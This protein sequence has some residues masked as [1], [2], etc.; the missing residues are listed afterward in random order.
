MMQ[1]TISEHFRRI[2]MKTTLVVMAA[3]IGS[4]YGQG[5]KQL[6]KVGPGGEMIIDY[7][8]YDAKEAGFDKVVFII[9]K[10][11]EEDFREAIGNRMSTLIP[12][13]YAFQEM[14]NLPEGFKVPE[15]RAK[16][17]GTGQA[18]MSCKGIVNEPFCVINADDYYGK[19]GFKIVH[20]YMI[21]RMNVESD[22]S[23]AGKFDMCMAGF[24]LKNT[25]S[26]NGGVTRGVCKADENHMLTQV[27][28]TFDIQLQPDGEVTA[29]D[30]MKNPVHGIS[31]D[32]I[33]SMNLW[34]L[35]PKFIDE[36]AAGFTDF[37]KERGTELKSEYLLPSVINNSIV[38]GKG[39]VKVLESH[40]KWFGV[41]Y[42]EDKEYVVNSIK[43]L[44][45]NGVYP[46]YLYV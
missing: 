3:G 5:I 25:L 11:L 32:D 22:G 33:V 38:N 30:E 8:V 2:K 39:T 43:K 28:E 40:D 31:A 23:G 10:D 35:P 9:R 46:K 20:D 44:I 24:V 13:E 16:P 15:G 37:M 41:T 18:V 29:V 12:V 1:M 26:E 17:W 34:G 27:T 21:N 45:E 42:H 6:E 4:R 19:E 7:S 14:D 36:I